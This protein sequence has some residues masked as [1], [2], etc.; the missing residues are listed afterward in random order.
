MWS[1]EH[2]DCSVEHVDS[3]HTPTFENDDCTYY[4]VS[5]VDFVGNLV[6]QSKRVGKKAWFRESGAR[7]VGAVFLKTENS[8]EHTRQTRA[9]SKNIEGPSVHKKKP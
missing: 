7:C 3:N 4:D 2:V 5:V 8:L 9:A 1:V 6:Q